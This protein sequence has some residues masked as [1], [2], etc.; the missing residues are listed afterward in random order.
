MPSMNDWNCSWPLCWCV[1]TSSARARSAMFFVSSTSRSAESSWKGLSISF[2]TVCSA[3]AFSRK[4]LWA[5][6]SAHDACCWWLHLSHPTWAHIQQLGGS[7]QAQ[8][9]SISKVLLGPLLTQLPL[10]HLWWQRCFVHGLGRWL[11]SREL[12][13]GLVNNKVSFVKLPG[14]F[15]VLLLNMSRDIMS[16]RWTGSQRV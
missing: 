15:W 6:R 8:L 3:S 1:P 2:N 11:Y 4:D 16:L 14:Y 12:P 9:P 5:L 10:H 7:V 13:S